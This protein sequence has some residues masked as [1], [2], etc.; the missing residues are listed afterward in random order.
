PKSSTAS[1]WR[2]WPTVSPGS[3]PRPDAWPETAP[4]RELQLQQVY[5][6]KTASLAESA[7]KK[8]AGPPRRLL[9][10]SGPKKLVRQAGGDVD[11]GVVRRRAELGQHGDGG[12]G[13]QQDERAVLDQHRSVLVAQHAEEAGALGRPRRG[14][15]E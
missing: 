4:K 10:F 1:R 15:S 6:I 9:P 5:A 8:P 14:W 13:E 3:C 11:E 2:P 7:E 12:D